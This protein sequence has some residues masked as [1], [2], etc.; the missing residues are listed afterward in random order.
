VETRKNG[1][2]FGRGL[3]DVV[4]AAELTQHI[5]NALIGRRLLVLNPVNFS[6]T[7]NQ[8]GDRELPI[9]VVV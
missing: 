4:V 2:S 5:G 9:I 7:A 3:S 1:I 6:L 8:N